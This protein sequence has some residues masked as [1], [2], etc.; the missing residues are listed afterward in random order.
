MGSLRVSR[1]I[2]WYLECHWLT[3]SRFER[4]TY[5]VDSEVDTTLHELLIISKRKLG[6]Y[7]MVSC[8]QL[9]N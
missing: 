7:L 2:S 1:E 3:K 4:G 9:V 5:K 8:Y 6:E